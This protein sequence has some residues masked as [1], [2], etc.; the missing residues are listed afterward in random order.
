MCLNSV[1]GTRIGGLLNQV[2]YNFAFDK[3]PEHKGGYKVYMTFA[4]DTFSTPAFSYSFKDIYVNADLGIFNSYSPIG[5]YTGTKNNLVL[6]VVRV[7]IASGFVVQENRLGGVETTPVPVNSDTAI[8]TLTATNVTSAGAYQFV[9]IN[10]N[11]GSYYCDNPPVYLQSKPTNNQFT[12]RLTD[13]DGTLNTL[14]TGSY[15]SMLLS[16]EAI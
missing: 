15:Y 16:F 1:D 7:D 13:L 8:Y 6:G 5:Q 9:P 10:E 12:V 4:S 3:T 2:V 11:V 14:F